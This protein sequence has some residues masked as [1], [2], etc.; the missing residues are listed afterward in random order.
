VAVLCEKPVG[1]SLAD[2]EA[3]ADLAAARGAPV[4]VVLNQRALAATRWISRLI[5]S[6]QLAPTSIAFS[7]DV[8]RLSGWHADST[9][10]GGGALRTLGIHYLDLLLWWL[11]EPSSLQAACSGGPS[12]DAFD[13]ALSFANGCLGRVAMAAR[14]ETSAGPIRC[15]IAGDRQ[16]LVMEGHRVVEATGVPPPPE[17]EGTDDAMIFGPGHL[18][19]IAEATAALGVGTEFPLP[20]REV[21]PVLRLIERIYALPR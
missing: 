21:L 16:R 8:A 11:G 4:G 12:E 19:V 5:Q 14:R 3:I 17:P 6:G 20:L 1:R 13:V 9:R 2:A 18:A 10:S 7:G 15:V